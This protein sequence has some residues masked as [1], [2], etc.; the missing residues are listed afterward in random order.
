M[1]VVDRQDVQVKDDVRKLTVSMATQMSTIRK[2]LASCSSA[3]TVNS[4]SRNVGK[5][6]PHYVRQHVLSI[7][8]ATFL[9]IDI[10][11]C[12]E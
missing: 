10:H 6:I 5:S 12:Q 9:V 1:Y 2:E 8:N 7:L 4:K 3:I 11:R